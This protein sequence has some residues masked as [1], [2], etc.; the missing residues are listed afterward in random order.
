MRLP[1]ALAA[2]AYR[3]F[4]LLWAGQFVDML[5]TQ[6][7]TVALGWLVYSLTGSTAALGGVGL[8]RAIPTILLSI[9][10]GTLADQVDRRRLLL[11]SQSFLAGL[12]ALLALIIS[13]GKANVPILYAF[14][15]LTAAAAAFDSPTRQALIPSLVPRER[16]PNALTLNVLAWQTAAVLGPA[17]GGVIIKVFGVSAAYWINAA[18][19]LVV[20]GAIVAMRTR[21]PVPAGPRRGLSAVVEGLEFVRGRAIL[22]QLM[23]VDFLAV[24]F[25]SSMGLLPVFAR[26]VLAVGSDGLGLL[27]SAPAAGAVAGS[28]IFTLLPTPR[29]PGRVVALAVAA[30]GISL[31]LFGMA[32]SFPVA[33]GLLALAGGLDAVSMAMR[34]TVR[35]LAT[36]DSLRGR[37]GALASVFSAGGPRLGEFQAGMVASV[38]GA[39]YAMV[40]GGGACL[41]MVVTS[42]WWA[43]QLWQYRGEELPEESEEPRVEAEVPGAAES[44]VAGVD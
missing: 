6:V 42:R 27:Y 9:F 12:S 33:L 4:R 25:V 2:L 18:S 30:Y 38:V 37:V 40:L 32:R 29:R 28:V 5:G 16:L 21:V 23:L 1:T 22:W 35:Q 36:P 15:A 39:R 3:D 41:L 11:V 43:R 7:Q 34:H 14:A 13:L 44:S 31:A 20:L 26:D 24:L 17:T 10:G 19:F 8:A